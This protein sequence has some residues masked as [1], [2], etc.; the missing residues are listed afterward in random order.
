MNPQ[1]KAL[2]LLGIA[3]RA[4]KLTTGDSFSLNEIQSKRAKIVILASDA[5]DNTR[6]KILDIVKEKNYVPNKMAQSLV[7]K[8]TKTIGVII[9]DIR[10]P[11]FTDIVRG[12]EDKAIREGYNIILCNTDENVEKEIK[13]FNTLTEKMVDVIIFAPSSKIDLNLKEYNFST[14]PIVLVDKKLDIKNLKGIVSLDNEEGTYLEINHLVENNHKKILYLSGPLKNEIA[15][16]RLKGYKKALKEANIEYDEKLVLQGEY[17]LDWGYEI[18]QSLK[19]INFTAICAAND[20]IAIG[21]IKA[22]KESLAEL[23]TVFKED[24]V[25]TAG[26]ASQM[27]DGASAVVLMSSDK[28]K[29]LGIK[30]LARIVARSVVGSDP[31]LMLTGPIAA[32]EKVLQK[33]GLTINDMDTYEVNEAFAPVPLAWL[34]DTGADAGKLNVDGGAIA[35]GHPLGATGTKLLTTMLYRM[36]RENQRYGLL[37]ICEGMGMANATIIEK[38]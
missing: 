25:I 4:G 29:E 18:I 3:T 23:K 9:P 1:Q 38:L 17:S 20:L 30:P 10:N 15:R 7:T 34:K 5:S 31:T 28:A 16:D 36:H 22:L 33:A 19:N 14:K 12:A 32:T 2:N 8:K 21:A 24:G 26:N 35:L 37:A 13:A 6:K 27:S 11:F